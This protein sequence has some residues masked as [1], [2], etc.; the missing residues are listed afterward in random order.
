MSDNTD[1]GQG[2]REDDRERGDALAR[3]TTALNELSDAAEA[4][5][6]HGGDEAHRILPLIHPS[7]NAVYQAYKPLRDLLSRPASPAKPPEAAETVGVLRLRIV[8][9]RDERMNNGL[10]TD[11]ARVL[12]DV[13]AMID[14]VSPA[15]AS[16][17]PT[18]AP[19]GSE[20]YVLVL[21]ETV[22]R[23][24]QIAAD[25]DDFDGDRRGIRHALGEA[26]DAL[27]AA[28]LAAAPHPTASAEGAGEDGLSQAARD[29]LAERRR[30]VE[31]EGW[32]AEHDDEHSRG[33]IA[34]AAACYA[35]Y[36]NAGE[37]AWVKPPLWPWSREWWRPGDR[38]RMLVKSGALILAE[39]ERQDRAAP[40][41]A[42]VGGA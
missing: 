9:E 7:F 12:N 38:R 13:L 16:L 39:I 4:W 2:G 30:Q 27:V 28:A 11:R 21:R 25:L 19:G 35:S 3:L 18:P 37:N 36:A 15:L 6:D 26:E 10:V 17:T 32:S 14:E 41:A 24:R 22:D 23:V 1:T 29:V 34:D 42:P 33:E 31:V 5:R 20:G 8:R 40:P